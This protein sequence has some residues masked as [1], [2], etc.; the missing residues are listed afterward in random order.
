MI[1]FIKKTALAVILVF[2]L[3]LTGIAQPSPP[4]HGEEENQPAPIGS[5]IVSLMVL[6]GAYGVKKVYDDKG[7]HTPKEPSA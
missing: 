7:S 4:G 2:I 6:A 1:H 3:A 5:G